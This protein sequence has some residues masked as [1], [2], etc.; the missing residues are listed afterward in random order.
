VSASV[1]PSSSVLC[2][3]PR[4]LT[5][6]FA[7]FLAMLALDVFEQPLGLWGTLVA[8]FLHLIPTVVVLAF[9]AAAWRRPWVGGAVYV[10]LGV[11]FLVATGGRAPWPTYAAIS[12]TLIVIGALFLLDWL[13]RRPLLPV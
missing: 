7:V 11:L 9:L 12:G 3:T 2:W 6:L 1:R 10:A 5:L 8:L 4:V 13:H